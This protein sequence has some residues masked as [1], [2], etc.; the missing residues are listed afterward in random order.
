MINWK[1]CSLILAIAGSANFAALTDSRGSGPS[2]TAGP[3]AAAQ[4]YG[5]AG[6]TAAAPEVASPAPAYAPGDAGFAVV[7]PPD[8]AYNALIWKPGNK[9]D[10]YEWWYYKVVLPG[11][12]DA[13]YFC[14]GVVNPWDT[15]QTNPASRAYLSAGSFGD[16]EVF[17]QDFKVKEFS[18]SSASTFVNIGGNTATDRA[19]KGRLAAPDG[20][21]ISW[22]L[23]LEKDWGVNLMG[24]TMY[25]DWISNIFW[26]P[27]QAGARMSGTINYR[28]RSV[29]LNRAPAYQDR[30]WGRSFPKWWTWLVSNNFK[31]SPGTILASGGGQPRIFPG[32][33]F[34][35][36]V[37]VGLRHQGR[38]YLFRP[39]G[40]DF[41]SVDINFG[42]WEVSARN[43]RG[44]RMEISAHAPR[45]K[46]LLLKFMTPQGETY[47]DYEALDGRINVKLYKGSKLIADLET[48]S[49]GI[50]FG[51]F[52]SYG[53]V[54]G[55]PDA[56]DF[57]ALF[58]GQNHLQ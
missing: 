43:Q 23:T 47:N 18:A 38:E 20:G 56:F 24:W 51:S 29:S 9:G 15:D 21:E 41:V 35:Q 17:E 46:F 1:K 33:D 3:A 36:T 28:G 30:N 7:R 6:M 4:L 55:A 50:E 16:R 34:I 31:N 5:Y 39:T 53:A 54:P 49:G 22:D 11:S 52:A 32:V 48:D 42:K 10:W 45:E 26:Y 12:T 2:G 8:A 27:A 40:G 37:T 57:E 19:L 14:Y 25:Q 58:S 44:E 13:F